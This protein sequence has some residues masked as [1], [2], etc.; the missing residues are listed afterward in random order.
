MG[1]QA[2]LLELNDGLRSLAARV[3]VVAVE[4]QRTP[5]AEDHILPG[6]LFD[7]AED[8]RSWLRDARKAAREALKNADDPAAARQ[9]LTECQHQL[10]RMR[11]GLACELRRRRRLADLSDLATRRGDIWGGWAKE[12]REHVHELAKV[13]RCVDGLISRCWREMAGSPVAPVQIH[14]LV[15]G[16]QIVGR[17]RAAKSRSR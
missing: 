4:A 12:T 11:G 1:V 16:K 13:W 6:I 9:A 10:E 8:A 7:A 2:A 3:K 14:N 15:V 5:H 17:Q